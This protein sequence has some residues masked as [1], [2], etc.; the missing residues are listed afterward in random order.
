MF[1]KDVHA[2]RCTDVR[3]TTELQVRSIKKFNQLRRNVLGTQEYN[4]TRF[5]DYAKIEG[6]KYLETMMKEHD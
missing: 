6:E 1:E 3:C 5:H 4:A 2:V